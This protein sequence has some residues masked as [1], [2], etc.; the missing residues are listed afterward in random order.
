MKSSY[1]SNYSV[2]AEARRRRSGLTNTGTSTSTLARP[3]PPSNLL[4]YSK[5]L[6]KT[7]YV[8]SS[9]PWYNTY[10]LCM[11]RLKSGPTTPHVMDFFQHRHQ[12]EQPSEKLPWCLL[13]RSVL[14]ADGSL[15]PRRPATPRSIL[16]VPSTTVVVRA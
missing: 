9:S 3:F 11:G 8:W 7:N 6:G 4:R 5:T 14:Y 2:R 1:K 16:R 12:E 13:P 15:V 10:V